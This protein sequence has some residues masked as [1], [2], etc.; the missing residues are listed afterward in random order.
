VDSS[1]PLDDF[2]L[3]LDIAGDRPLVLQEVGYP[4]AESLGSSEQ[5]QADFITNVFA[6]WDQAGS[7]IPF[8]SIF[9]LGDLSDDLMNQLGAYYGLAQDTNFLDYLRT[10]GLRQVDG[11]PKLAWQTFLDE[12]AHLN[13]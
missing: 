11:T 1:A 6:A 12:A 10:L 3:M 8:L 2:P 5:K 13:K 7:K 4:S 9:A